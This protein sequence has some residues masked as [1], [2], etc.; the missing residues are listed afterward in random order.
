MGLLYRRDRLTGNA[1]IGTANRSDRYA[2][3][4]WIDFSNTLGVKMSKYVEPENNQYYYNQQLPKILA[5]R[6]L[7]R[8]IWYSIAYLDS[9]SYLL[10]TT[11]ARLFQVAA[12]LFFDS[13]YYNHGYES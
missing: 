6:H 12:N 9:Y 8:I 5:C 11:V 1:N 7:L 10:P 2:S 3:D 13:L 4:R